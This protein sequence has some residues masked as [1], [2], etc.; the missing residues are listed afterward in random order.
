MREADSENEGG[1]REGAYGSYITQHSQIQ[2]LQGVFAL[3]E[4]LGW[5]FAHL[6]CV[7]PLVG[8]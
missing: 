6:G 8:D 2:L 3:K 1:V 5:L 7:F 4:H